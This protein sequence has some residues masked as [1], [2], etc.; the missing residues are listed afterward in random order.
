[1]QVL[2][3]LTNIADNFFDRQWAHLT[4]KFGLQGLWSLVKE[5]SC[6][7]VFLRRLRSPGTLLLLVNETDVD[8][9]SFAQKV[10]EEA[11]GEELV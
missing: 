7:P 3:L 4:D 5:V 11:F 8:Q 10:H 6:K 1:M 9:V 2:E